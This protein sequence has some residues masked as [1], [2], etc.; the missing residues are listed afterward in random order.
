LIRA[1]HGV[2][3]REDRLLRARL[4]GAS[5]ARPSRNSCCCFLLLFLAGCGAQDGDLLA[6]VFRRAG[7]KIEAAAGGTPNQFAGRLRT[8]TSP[9]GLADRVKTRLQWDRYLDGV[10]VEVE[11]TPDGVVKVKGRVPDLAKKER[12][13]D[14]AR[15]TSGV[16]DVVDE[17]Q[18]PRPDR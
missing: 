11:G 4:V 17:L 1:A 14:L 6:Q 10:T 5:L 7:Q 8:N 16:K 13:L 15:A 12:I 2:S 9:I 18:L 3:G